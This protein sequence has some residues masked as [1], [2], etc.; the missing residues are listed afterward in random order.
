MSEESPRWL[1]MLSHGQRLW[2]KKEI[3]EG[4][5]PDEMLE[6]QLIEAG[7]WRSGDEKANA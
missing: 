1:F 6:R 7:R 4:R 5:S 3:A 2:R